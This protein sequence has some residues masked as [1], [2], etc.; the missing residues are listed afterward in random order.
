[1]LGLVTVPMGS[2]SPVSGSKGSGSSQLCCLYIS[3][4]QVTTKVDAVR[5]LSA[6]YYPYAVTN[7]SSTLSYVHPAWIEDQ[8]CAKLNSPL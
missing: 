3:P 6:K 5:V 7:I 8:H 4:Q 1:M 2:V